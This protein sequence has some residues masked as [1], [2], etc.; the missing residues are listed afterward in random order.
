MDDTI[1]VVNAGSSSLKFAVWRADKV[2]GIP[3]L[4]GAV[5]GIGQVPHFIAQNADGEVLVDQDWDPADADQA[6]LF[7]GLTD[8]IGAH[9]AG[10]RLVAAGH[11][12]VHGGTRFAAPVVV[13]ALVM[14]ELEGLIPLAPLHQPHNLAAIRSLAAAHPHLP[15]VAC[16]DTAFHGGQAD[17][18]TRFALP[19]EFHDAGVRRY[20]FHGL[21]Y[22]YIT[23]AL[24][25]KAPELAA[26][27]VVIAHLGNGAS[28]CAVR[29]GKSVDSTMGFT[30]LDGLPMGT[31]IGNID[32]G[33]LLFLLAR[34][35][36]HEALQHLL[37][38]RSGLLG[39]SG[40]ISN[41]MR[42]LLAAKQPEAAQAV[43][44]F[45]YRVVR[46][47]GA[48]VACMGGIDGIVFTG[49]IGEHAVG[50]RE[51]ICLGCKWLGIE[52]DPAANARGLDRISTRVSRPVAWVIPTDEAQMIAIHTVAALRAVEVSQPA[53]TRRS[54]A[55]PAATCSKE[56][57]DA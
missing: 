25:R 11:R 4:K 36:G 17:V 45:V 31:R 32:A 56:L 24:A 22:D 49:G 5:T 40:G 2:E 33:V 15:Q 8:W 14:R 20:G 53:A 37:Y 39:V 3:T 51:R 12:V 46:E 52:L 10:S 30:A 55:S 28:L 29:D 23:R 19:R 27:R 42:E 1:L 41:D 35:M 34:G 44:L 26:G 50:I 13:D 6:A 54:T 16:F 48:M 38:N 43:D 47:I 21:S 18:A 7:G 57:L 9:G